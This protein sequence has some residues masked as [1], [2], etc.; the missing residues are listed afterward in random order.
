MAAC[1]AQHTRPLGSRCEAAVWINTSGEDWGCWGTVR[2]VGIN[3]ACCVGS[4]QLIA[5]P[6]NNP[7]LLHLPTS[8]IH[9]VLYDPTKQTS[10]G[11]IMC[12]LSR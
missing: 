9:I 12:S 7:Q 4:F 11:G 10:T 6:L 3:K 5:V 8:C 1:A 2:G